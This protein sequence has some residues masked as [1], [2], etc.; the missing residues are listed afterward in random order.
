MSDAKPKLTFEVSLVEVAGKIIRMRSS[1]SSY[2]CKRWR[3]VP[4]QPAPAPGSPQYL[5]A[6]L[7]LGMEEWSRDEFGI[8]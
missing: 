7:L 8:R 4:I 1:A 6:L 2:Y 3:R 5:I